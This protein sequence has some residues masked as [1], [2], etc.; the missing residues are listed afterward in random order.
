M[1]K[2]FKYK[3]PFYW[4]FRY[5]H[6]VDDHNNLRHALPSIEDTWMTDRWEC[7]VFAFI[8]DISEVNAFLILRYFFYCGLHQEGMPGILEFRRK[9]AWKI[10]NNIC[11]GEWEGGG[12]LFPESIHRFINA[13][14]N[15]RR[16]QNRRWICTADT[17]YQQYSCRFKYRKKIRTYCICTP[18]VWICSYCYVKHVLIA[19]SDD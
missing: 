1:V 13:S 6:A 3:L 15:A 10:I 4:R 11:I 19:S 9:L 8:L 5:C 2:K 18:G 7:R 17:A 14:R 12:E 16:Y